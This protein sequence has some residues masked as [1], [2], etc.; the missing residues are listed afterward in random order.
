MGYSVYLTRLIVQSLLLPPVG[1]LY[2]RFGR[3]GYPASAHLR[4]ADGGE[5][6]RNRRCS[7]RAPEGESHGGPE[8]RR[9]CQPRASQAPA[10]ERQ[11]EVAGAAAVRRRR[12]RA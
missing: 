9:H 8:R 4:A 2:G 10:E 1:D 6:T 11:N 5:A 12:V 3:G 7:H